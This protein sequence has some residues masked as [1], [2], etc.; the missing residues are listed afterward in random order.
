MY[1]HSKSTFKDPFRKM[2]PEEWLGIT[3]RETD[4]IKCERKIDL[5]VIFWVLTLG[6]VVRLHRMVVHY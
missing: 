6:F 2:F 3:A 1:T 5:T 4:L